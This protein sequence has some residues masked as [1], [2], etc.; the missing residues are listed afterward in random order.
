MPDTFKED[1]EEKWDGIQTRT[2]NSNPGI[3]GVARK[4]LPIIYRP[5]S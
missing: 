1:W 2:L 4:Y 5:W 3:P